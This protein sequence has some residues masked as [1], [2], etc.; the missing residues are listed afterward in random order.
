MRSVPYICKLTFFALC[1]LFAG[2]VGPGM[3]TDGTSVSVGTHASGALRSAA[4][5]PFRGPG[6]NMPKRWRERNRNFGT[7]EL[8]VLVRRVARR[9]NKRYRGSILGV[10][11]ISPLGG[12]PTK[13]HGSHRSGRDVD[14]L[15]YA[16]SADNKSLAPTVMIKFDAS[17]V[18]A[19][20][21]QPTNQP[22]NAK[23]QPANAKAQPSSGTKPQNASAE[24]NAAAT[25]DVQ[26]DLKRNWAMIK[27]LVT[28]PEVPV[29]WIFVG[30]GLIK[31]ML[32]HARK[33]KEPNE[34]IQ[35]AAEVLRQP[36]D[37][38]PHMDHLHVRVFCS[39]SD[40]HQG[41]IDRGP[42]R[43]LKKGIKYIDEPE[44][45]PEVPSSL[46][47]LVLKKLRLPLL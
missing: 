28:D 37:A 27:A 22:T 41:C 46:R 29:Q 15:Y 45:G 7:D 34:L 2:C 21:S 40:R 5:L 36:G 42:P 25:D 1:L 32:A 12:G 47:R 38:S 11:D 17:G 39:P 14:L 10:A 16:V 19:A 44:R 3:L 9:V 4:K 6:Y 35:R 18:G 43:W 31:L 8:V 24:K 33:T 13:E 23:S 30:R 26:F 20:P